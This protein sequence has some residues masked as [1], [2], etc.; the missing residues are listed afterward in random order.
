[1]RGIG[2]L[3]PEFGRGAAS[4]QAAHRS[5]EDYAWASLMLGKPLLGQRVTDIL[6]LS[7]ALRT[8][9]QLTNRRL[10][11]NA[12]GRLTVPATVAAAVDKSVDSLY[13]AGGLVS[14]QSILETEQYAADMFGN[15]CFSI[16][17]H[18]DLPS[19]VAELAPR[20][21]TMAG[22][23]D[24]TGNA[25]DLAAVRQVYRDAEAKGHIT[26]RPTADW[27]FRELLA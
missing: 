23:V 22:A 17:R 3:A 4:Y 5:E 18:T 26:L 24:A 20:K 16:L 11:L 19:I 1:L 15:F 27:Q 6:A 21:V 13:L 12:N 2:D 10:A 7:A 8:H 9:P 14:F 25:L